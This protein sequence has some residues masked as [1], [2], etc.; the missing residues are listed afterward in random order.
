MDDQFSDKE[1]K[2]ILDAA[3]IPK[4]DENARKRALNMAVSEFDMAQKEAREHSAQKNQKTFQGFSI[5]SRLMGNTNQNGRKPMKQK[6]KK[7]LIYGGMATAMAVVLIAGVSFTQLQE[8]NQSEVAIISSVEPQL[9][10]TAPHGTEAESPVYRDAIEEVQLERL[11]EA[12]RSGASAIPTPKAPPKAKLSI[13]NQDKDSLRRLRK[14]QEEPQANVVMDEAAPAPEVSSRAANVGNVA[15]KSVIESAESAFHGQ[16]PIALD[17]IIAPHPP[18]EIGRDKFEDFEENQIKLVAE[19]PVSTFSA[20]VDTASYAF[21]RRQLNNG[22]LPQKDAVRIE[23]LINYFDYDYTVPDTREQPFKANVSITDSPWADG[24]KLMHIG[25]KGFDIG[26]EKPKSNIVF[27]LDVSGSMNQQDRLPLLKNSMKMLLDTLDEDDT[28]AIAVY[29][30]AAGTVLEPTPASDK[31]KIMQAIN[32]LQAGGGTAGAEGIKL[33]YEL[34][35]AH[36]DDEAVNR[37]ILATDGDFNVGI[38]DRDELQDFVERKRES[39]LF[40]S[41]LGFGQG[42]YNDHMMQTLAQNGNGTAAYIDTLN[43]ARKVLVDEASSTL[44]PIAKDVKFQIEFNAQAVSEYRLIGYETRALNRE[45]FNNDTV[46]AGDIGAGHSVT[47]IYEFTPAGNAPSVDPLRYSNVG[48]E[49]A[50]D[51]K[52][53]PPGDFDGEYAFLK[54]RYKLP[55]ADVSKLITAP[56]TTQMYTKNANDDTRFASAVAAFGQKLKGGKYMGDFSYDNIIAL[57]Q[58]AKG[59]DPFGYRA[60]FINLVRLAKTADAME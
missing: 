38:T 44:F 18:K 60:E 5:L 28:V 55:D 16:V 14:L 33:A 19:E 4:P 1:L 56:V 58:N 43:E 17:D 22:V 52:L 24:K 13:P 8:F 50:D 10:V 34:A 7:K 48:R 23:E 6:P 40:L 31:N 42:N 46:D 36:F 2:A 15:N 21:V 47:A 49:N 53:V 35:A 51:F 41:V 45:D 9:D 37:V 20:D 57:A 32:N 30:G 26:D 59:D 12:K 29:A 27:L 11:A 54:M 39:G 25:I 3:D